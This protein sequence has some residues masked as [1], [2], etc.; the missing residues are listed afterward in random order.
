MH[1]HSSTPYNRPARI[2]LVNHPSEARV[3]KTICFNQES[4]DVQN[5]IFP[6][7]RFAM[8]L[9]VSSRITYKSQRRLGER[10]LLGSPKST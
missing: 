6:E 9:G 5:M 2:G 4:K 7:N 10:F 3:V 8:A 1:L